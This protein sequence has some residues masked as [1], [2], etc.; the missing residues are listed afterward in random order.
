MKN[1]HWSEKKKIHLS[2]KC[3]VVGECGVVVM[4]VEGAA[5]HTV[6]ARVRECGGWRGGSRVTRWWV[7][8]MELHDG[9]W[10]CWWG[11]GMAAWGYGFGWLWRRPCT[12]VVGEREGKTPGQVNVVTFHWIRCDDHA[13]SAS[14]RAYPSQ[15]FLEGR[16]EGRK[17]IHFKGVIILERPQTYPDTT[18]GRESIIYKGEE[19]ENWNILTETSRKE[20]DTFALV[21]SCVH[22]LNLIVEES[23]SPSNFYRPMKHSKQERKNISKFIL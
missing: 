15:V 23:V 14:T 3:C 8:W 11:V 9:A 7:V 12:W 22:K 2:L 5:E 16:W 13:S 1:L 10:W 17:L 20:K 19:I 18:S 21:F 6:V 4:V